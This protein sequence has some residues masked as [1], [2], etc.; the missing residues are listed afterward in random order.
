METLSE[1]R[2]CQRNCGVN[3]LA[4]ELGCCGAGKEVRI[5]RAALHEWEEPCISGENGSGTI[6]F[7][8]CS[9]RCVYCQ[10]QAISRGKSGK[11]VSV[12]R[13]AEIC[14]ELQLQGA[15]NIN[16]VTPTH[17][18]PQIVQALAIARDQ[19]LT[20]P[21]VYNCGGYESSQ[22]LTLLKG[23]V[24]IYL[25]DFKYFSSGLAERYSSAPDYP[26]AVKESL[27]EMFRQV[28]TPVFDEDGMMRRGMIIRHLM[29]PGCLED[30][31]QVVTYLYHTFGDAVYLSLMNQYTPLPQ[32]VGYPELNRRIFSEEYAELVD[33]AVELGVVNGF[34]Q[35][36]GTASESFIPEFDCFGV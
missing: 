11:A 26:E 1:C 5:A 9:L 27:A 14:L 22:S 16:L 24:D 33:Y 4:G 8:H 30:S 2:L 31:K 28:G 36:E 3:R 12:E 10:N 34:T 7:S 29:L 35:E 15:H 17:Y 18:V 23:I 20:L 6:F 25:P 13:L 19:G 21:I 32:V